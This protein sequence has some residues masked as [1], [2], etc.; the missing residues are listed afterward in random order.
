MKKPFLFILGLLFSLGIHAQEGYHD[1]TALV[2]LDK[3]GEYFGELNSLK[4]TT[5]SSEDIAFSDDFFIKEFKTS[6]FILQGSDKMAVKVYRQGEEHFYHYNGSQLVYYSLVGNFYSAADA[7]ATT[8][9]TMDWLSDE[10][11]I[12]LVVAD[13]L[14]PNFSQNMI[15]AMDYLEFLGQ[16][17]VDGEKTFHIGGANSEMTFQLWVNQD[18]EMKPIKAVL[19]YFGEPY[20]R[21]VE[22]SFDSWEINQTYP[23]SIFEFLPPPSSKQIIWTKKN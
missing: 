23:N 9:E 11:G 7:P 15:D 8:L 17:H 18:L 4:F 5:R 22:V 14:Y 13:F 1:S 20:S 6:E 16:A 2:I 19:T 10:F 21:Q 3:V 12:D